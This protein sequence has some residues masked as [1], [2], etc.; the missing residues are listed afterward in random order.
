MDVCI[1][2]RLAFG[3]G[4]CERTVIDLVQDYYGLKT[5]ILL[6]NGLVFTVLHEEVS[7]AAMSDTAAD[8][9]IL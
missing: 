7:T 6:L 8:V 4:L 1:A 9:C 3:S 2:A 5:C